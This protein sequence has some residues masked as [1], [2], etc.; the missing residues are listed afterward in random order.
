MSAETNFKFSNRVLLVPM[1]S[2]LLIWTIFWMELKF[3]SNWNNYGIYPRTLTGLRGIV[4]G[5]FLHGSVEHLY[6][7]SMPLAILMSSLLYF[8]RSISF[9]VLFWGLL[10][11]GLITWA[12]GRPSYHIGA[13]G[14]IYLLASFIFFKGIFTKHYRLVAVSL[15]VS[16]IYGSMLW[17][18]FPIKEEISW[19]GHLGGFLIGLLMALFLK[20][21]LPIIPKY[22]WEKE[23]YNEEE[24]E[25]L[26]HFDAE[27]NFIE[28]ATATE[29]LKEI[30]VNYHYKK[31]NDK[32]LEDEN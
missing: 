1:A 28:R 27:G 30:Q 19:E 8:Y 15:I 20:A 16:F 21:K 6:N 26:Q 18:I 23:D 14:I 11:S 9:K 7:N 5:P 4:F 13:S 10:L 25:F 22:A 17:Y 12:I 2:V 32:S 29:D 3:Q 31:G 24:D